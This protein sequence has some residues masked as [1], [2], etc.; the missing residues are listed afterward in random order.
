MT[1]FIWTIVIL[2][3][4]EAFATT[5]LIV[6]QSYKRSPVAMVVDVL[7]SICLIGWGSFLLGAGN[8]N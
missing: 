7:L 4:L 3:A 5:M 6:G 1:A 8:G 2:L